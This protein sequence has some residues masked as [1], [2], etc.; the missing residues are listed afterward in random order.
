[1]KIK[2]VYLDWKK[3]KEL[4]V[5][6]SS[7]SAYLLLCNNHIVPLFGE[8]ESVTEKIV[9]DFVLL[10][11]KEGM[12]HKTIKDILIV[13]KMI[14]K[15]GKKY[16]MIEYE[17]YDILFP[18]DHSNHQTQVLTVTDFKKLMTHVKEN[19]SF[20]SMGILLTMSTGLRI[21]EVCALK[22][23]DINIENGTISISKTLQRIYCE[24]AN[25]KMKTEIVIDSAKTKSSQREI[26]LSSDLMKIMKPLLKLVRPEYYLLTCSVKPTEPRTYRAFYKELMASIDLPLIKFHG[27]RHTFASR[28]IGAK[29]DVKTVSVILGHANVSTTFNLYVHPNTED[30]KSAIS[31]MFKAMR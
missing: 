31:Q 28:M 22:W 24:D 14:L 1:M 18:A 16:R 6:R 8:L 21:G 27:L 4:Y 23:E 15:H 3:S 30:K 5:K 2:E 11:I 26:P 13:L 7:M 17:P 10:K 25:G 29:V 19:F 9:Q 20:K 12:G